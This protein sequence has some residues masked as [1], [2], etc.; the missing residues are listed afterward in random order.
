M[1]DYKDLAVLT[2][3]WLLAPP[4]DP[5]VD[6]YPDGKIDFRDLAEFAMMWGEEL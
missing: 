5:N 1:I 2:D 4:T 6:L 3:N